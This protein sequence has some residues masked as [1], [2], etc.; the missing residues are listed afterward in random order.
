MLNHVLN[1]CEE[2]DC[3]GCGACAAL[4]PVSA[5]SMRENSYAELHPAIEIK[6]CIN[7]G[8]CVSV[9]PAVH[10][11]KQAYPSNVYASVRRDGKK[12]ARSASGG[13]GALLA[14]KFMLSGGKYYS[15]AMKGNMAVV[16]Q[17]RNAEDIENFKGSFYVQSE[18]GE[19]Y[20]FIADDLRKNQSVL[21]IGTPCQTA[22]LR[23]A[24]K[25]MDEK[26]FTVDLLCHGVAPARYL[27]EYI[28]YICKFVLKKQSHTSVSFRSNVHRCDYVFCL[29]NAG[30]IVY[31]MPSTFSLYFREFLKGNIFREACYRCRFKSVERA[32]DLSIGDFIGLGKHIRYD[33]DPVRVSMIIENSQKGKELLALIRDDSIIENRTIEEALMEGSSLKSSFPRTSKHIK[34]KELYPE[35]GFIQAVVR[36]DGADMIKDFIRA[37][38]QKIMR[39][40]NY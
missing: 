22:G 38:I 2:D 33:G 31:R 20:H 25:G 37:A 30:D 18:M 13:M 4:C 14:E 10:F 16:R 17:C 23:N 5:L 24:M 40:C 6:K 21:F 19:A 15:T 12:R 35:R 1:R 3:T 8:K 26:L 7:C 28:G 34:F 11:D 29:W 27:D 39:V 36:S 32:G 9:C